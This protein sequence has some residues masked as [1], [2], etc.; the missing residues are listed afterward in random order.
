MEFT[1]TPVNSTSIQQIAPGYGS[2]TPTSARE[3][4]LAQQ[5]APIATAISD[6]PELLMEIAARIRTEDAN[7]PVGQQ[8][9]FEAM[10]NNQIATSF[11]AK[12]NP[13]KGVDMLGPAYYPKTGDPAAA[14]QK[15]LALMQSNPGEFGQM[16]EIMAKVFQGSNISQGAF[17]WSQGNSPQAKSDLANARLV[18]TSPQTG[19]DFNVFY[20]P[21][22]SSFGPTY[23]GGQNYWLSQMPP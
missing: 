14:Y 19:K 12:G 2:F 4:W 10:L 13:I 23:I 15:N 22:G 18:Y 7:S 3:N 11:D 20:Q 17:G 1:G 21:T 5:R 9:V 8:A 6:N 16:R